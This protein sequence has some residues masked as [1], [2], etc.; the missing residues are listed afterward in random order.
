MSSFNQQTAKAETEK[1]SI[2]KKLV[3]VLNAKQKRQCLGIGVLI[4][5]SG[6]LE[7]LGVSMIVPIVSAITAPKAITEYLDKYPFLRHFTD[8]LGLTTTFR[9]T[10]AML[11]ALMAIYIVKH[12]F[13]LFVTYLQNRFI[14]NARNDMTSRVLRDFLNRPYE[15][16]LGA[17]IPTVFRIT[18]SDIPQTF[19][20]ILCLL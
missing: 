19:S 7:T 5:I 10:I 14:T 13:L 2:L 8:S 15:D 3:Y 20:L 11:V 6:I 4:L 12:A 17:D 18:D 1:L 9:L 16:Y